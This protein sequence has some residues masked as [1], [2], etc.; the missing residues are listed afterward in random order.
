LRPKNEELW[1]ALF[2]AVALT[3]LYGSVLYATRAIPA[4]GSLFGHLLGIIGFI[5]MLMTEVLYSLRKRS[6]RARWG[7]M[8]TWLKFHI[9]TGLV[10]P[11]MVLLHSSWKFHGLA[12]AVTLLTLLIVASGFVG[13]YIYTRIPRSLDGSETDDSARAAGLAK[14]RRAMAVW[15]AVH[16]PLGMATFMAAFFHIG[17]ALYYSTLLK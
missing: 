8:E 14:T 4:A 16:I 11:Y 5:L 13:R 2:I 12:G 10:G 15:Y 6:R 7:S 3:A 1:L 9:L 17:A